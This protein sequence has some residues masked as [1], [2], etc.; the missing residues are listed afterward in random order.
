MISYYDNT[1]TALKVAHCRNA[2]CSSA[3]TSLVDSAGTVGSFTSATVGSDGLAL[4]S[5]FDDTSFD[6]KVAHC[7]NTFCTSYFRPR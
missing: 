2:A 5:Y 4:I 7:A 1:N 3:S 6:L